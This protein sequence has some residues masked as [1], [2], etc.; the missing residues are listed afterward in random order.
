MFSNS[1]NIN[2][3]NNNSMFEYLYDLHKNSKKEVA[4][5]KF[6]GVV[7]TL[8]YRKTQTTHGDKSRLR[9]VVYLARSKQKP[10][11]SSPFS[12]DYQFE[13]EHVSFDKY[14]KADLPALHLSIR[15]QN[16]ANH[17]YV[18]RLDLEVNGTKINRKANAPISIKKYLTGE[19]PSATNVELNTNELEN[20][21]ENLNQHLTSYHLLF[22][23]LLLAKTHECSRLH[24]KYASLESSI[25]E[26]LTNLTEHKNTQEENDVLRNEIYDFLAVIGKLNRYQA[27]DQPIGEKFIRE[28]LE[29]LESVAT[30]SESKPK[31]NE[32]IYKSK[33]QDAPEDKLDSELE[34]NTAETASAILQAE[35][36]VLSTQEKYLNEAHTTLKEI[37]KLV[38]GVIEQ[39]NSSLIKT[40][41][42]KTNSLFALVSVLNILGTEGIPDAQEKIREYTEYIHFLEIAIEEYQSKQKTGQITEKTPERAK[43]L[44]WSAACAMARAS[45]TFKL[46]E[47]ESAL[48]TAQKRLELLTLTIDKLINVIFN[49]EKL[50]PAFYYWSLHHKMLSLL[51]EH[52]EK[53]NITELDKLIKI[54]ALDAI[55]KILSTPEKIDCRH[56]ILIT[57]AVNEIANEDAIPLKLSAN[58]GLNFPKN[59]LLL[60]TRET[61]KIPFINFHFSSNPTGGYKKRERINHCLDTVA[62]LCYLPLIEPSECLEDY[63]KRINL[64]KNYVEPIS[65]YSE[66]DL[67][68]ESLQQKALEKCRGALWYFNSLWAIPADVTIYSCLCKVFHTLQLIEKNT[69]NSYLDIF[70]TIFLAT[71]A[72]TKVKSRIKS[73][74]EYTALKDL[75]TQQKQTATMSNSSPTTPGALHSAITSSNCF[76]AE[77]NAKTIS[78]ATLN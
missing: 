56:T 72:Q 78:T 12:S 62:S 71:V 27:T 1:I 55:G 58:S 26:K 2:N 28:Q 39:S 37:I 43:T 40:I 33:N 32:H 38:Y 66:L 57:P 17:H 29:K 49:Q 68:P 63:E 61:Y 64:F 65:Q 30:F 50:D 51:V 20:L 15:Y 69:K 60:L 77:P 75:V 44:L 52:L 21:D 24:E 48:E 53:N 13:S 18:I 41:E 11:S 73:S 4:K 23:N 54:S 31:E 6:S 19:F 35:T 34:I 22:E 67:I 47:S 8:N 70:D 76:T 74:A 36:P 25:S 7:V 59:K 46:I 3:S 16:N 9:E 45:R 10:F 42:R 14:P 5:L